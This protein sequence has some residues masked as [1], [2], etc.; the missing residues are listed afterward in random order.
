MEKHSFSPIAWVKGEIKLFSTLVRSV[1]TLVIVLFSCSVILMNLLSSFTVVDLPYFALTG[2]VFISWAAFLFMDILSKH[3]GPKAANHISWIALTANL[4]AVGIF[5]LI[6][7]IGTVPQLDMILHGQWS[8][9]LASTVAFIVSALINNLLNYLIGLC[10]AE[11]P[12]SKTAYFCR[13]YVSTFVGQVIDN[14]VFGSLAFIILPMIPD[15]L[16]VQWTWTQVS[17]CAVTCA[18]AELAMEVVFSPIVYAVTK[19]W[20]EKGVG[21]EYRD[22]YYPQIAESK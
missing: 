1:P 17:I 14:F 8:I 6:S 22:L 11:N 4:V 16:Q 13:S 19:R 7:Q 10:F 12:D 21:K 18:L 20:R 5:F 9:L 2:G 15:A 3:F